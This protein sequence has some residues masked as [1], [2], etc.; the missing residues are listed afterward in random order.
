MNEPK[1]IKAHVSKG[2]GADPKPSVIP[3]CATCAH[4]V[5]HGERLACRVPLPPHVSTS[6]RSPWVTTNYS[7]GMFTTKRD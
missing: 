4:S 5:P 6:G 3:S 2:K 1:T 7:C